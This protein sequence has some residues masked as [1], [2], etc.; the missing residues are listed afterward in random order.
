MYAFAV[1][2]LEQ[3]MECWIL[4]VSEYP[5]SILWDGSESSALLDLFDLTVPTHAAW[6]FPAAVQL[7]RMS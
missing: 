2:L 7:A 5:G 4:F 6:A 3:V 1:L